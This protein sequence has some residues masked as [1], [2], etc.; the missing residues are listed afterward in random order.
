MTGS[1]AQQSISAGRP[2]KS[3]K[4]L[5]FLARSLQYRKK[6]IQAYRK[7]RRS[8]GDEYH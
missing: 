1:E 8:V 2:V 3:R 7:I 5:N 4:E 6:P